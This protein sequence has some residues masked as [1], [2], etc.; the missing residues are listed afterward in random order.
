MLPVADLDVLA[1]GGDDLKR[2]EYLVY[3]LSTP[4]S[5]PPTPK[6]F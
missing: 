6:V 3:T 4:N 2:A 1:P 5:K